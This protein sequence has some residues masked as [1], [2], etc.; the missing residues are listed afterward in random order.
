ML[1][2]KTGVVRCV[3]WI[4]AGVLVWGGFVSATYYYH[5]DTS[6]VTRVII[7]AAFGEL[8]YLRAKW[9]EYNSTDVIQ[10]KHKGFHNNVGQR[11]KLA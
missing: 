8:N 6:L 9:G 5:A 3:R 1:Y 4:G 11:I 10:S 2:V 7:R